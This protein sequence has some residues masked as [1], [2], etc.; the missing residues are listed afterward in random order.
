MS[1][2]R[3]ALNLPRRHEPD[4]VTPRLSYSLKTQATP[5]LRVKANDLT[6]WV[7]PWNHLV[8]GRHQLQG[9][10]DFLQLTFVSQEVSIYGHNL[11]PLVEAAADFHLHEVHSMPGSGCAVPS[12]EP[13]IEEIKVRAVNANAQET[14][15]TANNL[16]LQADGAELLVG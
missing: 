11:G 7:L 4:T 8:H 13:F 1:S 10:R 12:T 6:Q 5:A 16:A 2:L 3:K 15:Q 14:K 9:K